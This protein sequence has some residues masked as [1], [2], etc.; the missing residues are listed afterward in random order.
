MPQVTKAQPNLL[1]V[2]NPPSLQFINGHLIS[3]PN[4]PENFIV[5]GYMLNDIVYSIVKMIAD[6]CSVAP[7]GLYR[8]KDEQAYKLFSAEIRKKDMSL[9]KVGDMQRKALEP[10]V[11]AG[12]WSE[13]IEYPNDS[14]DF[15]TLTAWGVA[16]KLL[17]GNK[18]ISANILNGGVNAGVPFDLNIEPSH[19]MNIIA[20]DSWPKKAL[21]YNLSI[22][23]DQ[24]FT[25]E[26]VLHERY[27]NPQY[28]VAG[29]QLYGMSP[30]KAGLK[31][32]QKSNLQIEAEASTWQNEGIKGIIALKNQAGNVGDE[33]AL[34]GQVQQLAETV[35]Q[36][37]SGAGTKGRMGV[38][39]YDLSWIPIG[40]NSEEMSLIESGWVDLRMMCNWFGGVPS[41]LLNDPARSTYN[42][43][44]EAEKALTTRCAMPEL[45]ATKSAYNRKF[46]TD[47]GLPK[48]IIV[49]FDISMFQELQEDVAKIALWTSQI[50]AISPNEQRELCGLGALPDPQ[51]SEPHV[52][53]SGNRVPLSE[54]QMNDVDNALNED[55]NPDD[56][57]DNE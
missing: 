49:D 48:G 32:L 25:R 44:S 38:S 42:T 54:R 23:A 45:C 27:F 50:M 24:R 43:V 40:L 52:M 46:S 9:S 28:D 3:Y 1:P 4:N 57:K 35:R 55:K 36:E 51:M 34:Q 41:Q 20:S 33:D 13:L 21:A 39:G 47:W 11:N 37:W 31:R 22:L 19:F 56:G 16:F 15:S 14:N 10:V 5:K 6:K 12:K 7:W 30:L 8:I 17:T 26:E 53:Q 2:R 18:F 29:S